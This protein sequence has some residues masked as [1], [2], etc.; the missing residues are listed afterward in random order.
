MPPLATAVKPLPEDDAK[1]PGINAVLLGPPGSGKGT[2]VNDVSRLASSLRRLILALG[3]VSERVLFDFLFRIY[4]ICFA[5]RVHRHQ[6]CWRSSTC[7]T[8]PPETCSGP[9]W[10]PA[11]N[12][13]NGW[14]KWSTAVCINDRLLLSAISVTLKVSLNTCLY[15]PF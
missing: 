9:K 14:N 8:C 11:P 2:Q 15:C 12:W 6:S 1:L 13:E 3:L 4:I 10:R 7:V 5:Y